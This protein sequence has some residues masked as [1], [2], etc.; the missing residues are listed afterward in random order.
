MR[1]LITQQQ[2][3]RVALVVGRKRRD[4]ISGGAS[5]RSSCEGYRARAVVVASESSWSA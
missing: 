2:E 3:R 1:P 5:N 4:V